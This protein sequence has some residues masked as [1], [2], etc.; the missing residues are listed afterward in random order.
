MAVGCLAGVGAV[1]RTR[2]T[3]PHP[4]VVNFAV[5][6]YCGWRAWTPLT[7]RRTIP[8]VRPNFAAAV[9]TLNLIFL[10]GKINSHL[11]CLLFLQLEEYFLQKL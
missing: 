3:C 5:A 2:Y 4:Q 9:A 7:R 11:T 8:R 6:G 1:A 10:Q